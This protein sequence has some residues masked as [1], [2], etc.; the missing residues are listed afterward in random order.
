MSDWLQSRLGL[1]PELQVKL[2]VTL[3][4]VFG[5]WLLH[6]IVLS[7]VYRRVR[8]PW[9]RYRWRKSITYVALGLGVILVGRTWFVG[10]QA[11]ATFLGLLTAGLAIALKDP[12][13]NLAGWIF[14]VW[15]R[16][17]EVSD[18]VEIGGHK[19]D[20]IDRSE[21]HTSELQSHSDLVCRLLLEKKK[22]KSAKT[23]TSL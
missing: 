15:R 22:R 8:D 14:I 1:S 4:T 23:T 12:V 13:T 5:L 9:S 11:L 10:I 20:V 6:W 19:G 2:L 16:P 21:E 3:L 17:F 7:L 18:R